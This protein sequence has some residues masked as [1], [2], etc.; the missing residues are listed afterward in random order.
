ME[1]YVGS[2]V[3]DVTTDSV[4]TEVDYYTL[5]GIRVANPGPGLYIRRQGP[6]A[7]K[8]LLQ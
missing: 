1:G 8:V 3:E 7:T 4:E 5:Q 6:T 2:G